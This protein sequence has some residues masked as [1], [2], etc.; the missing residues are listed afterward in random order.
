VILLVGSAVARAADY[1]VRAYI[2]PDRDI[3]DTQ[4]V[5]LVIQVEGRVRPNVQ[6]FELARL[7]NLAV[8]SGPSTQTKFVATPGR[9]TSTLEL[10]YTLLP[11]RAGPAQ[12]PGFDVLVDG[13][14]YQTEPIR[15]EVKPTPKGPSPSDPRGSASGQPELFLRAELGRNEVWVGE[16]VPLTVTLYTALRVL[17][18]G[19]FQ[20]PDLERFWVERREVD[21]QGESYR[22]RIAGRVYTAV[23][24]EGWVLIPPGPGEFELAPFVAQVR[25]RTGR[26]DP[27][28]LC[29]MGRG[30]AVVRRSEPLTL[31]V[32]PL[33]GGGR[34][35]DFNGAVGNFTMKAS[36]DRA[37]TFVNDAVAI[38]VT[39]RGDGSLRSV[40]PPQLVAPGDLTVFEPQVKS[41]SL[42]IDGTRLVS[43][44]TWEWIV[45]PLVAGDV[46]LP[47]LRFDYFDPKSGRYDSSAGEPLLLTV[48]RGEG[49]SG[50]AIATRKITGQRELA[51][52]KPLSGALKIEHARAHE[53][54]LFRLLFLL[55]FGLA[56][57]LVLV[58]RKRLRL[59]RDQG[60]ARGRRAR[61]RARKRLHA[62]GKRSERGETTSFHEELARTLIAYVADRCNRSAA[63]LTY[64]LVDEL[65]SAQGI[66]APLRARLRAC[67]ET[68][69]YARFVPS[70]SDTARR[71]ELLAEAGQVIEELERAW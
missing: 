64:D 53:S 7:K 57:V 52:I 54:G 33:P 3:T 24:L 42:S 58:G 17:D 23:P 12:I 41:S 14:V 10:S 32:K 45:I 8:V 62:I 25:V 6:P 66:A 55:P 61:S 60:L 69:D 27:F 9:T 18:Y 71:D 59:Q 11:N 1:R 5:R 34:P 13:Q 65:L 46:E 39:V 48:Q 38:Q 63:G 36:M 31:K 16:A 56:P 19:F 40:G 4:S 35:A 70:A 47:A 44:K 43:S 49:P 20:T 26:G 30:Q 29:S 2:L 21:P 37:E 15:F 22:T 50:Q 28:D 51:F 68:C 67:V